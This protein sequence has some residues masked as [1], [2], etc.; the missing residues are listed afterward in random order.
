MLVNLLILALP[1]SGI[2][3]LRI[4][5][6]ALVRQTESE[7]IAQG[8]FI[9]AAYRAA[10]VRILARMKRDVPAREQYGRTIAPQW[11]PSTKSESPWRPRPAVLDLAVDRVRPRPPEPSTTAASVDPVAAEVGR[12]LM[13]LIR[14]AQVTTLASIRVVDYQGMLVASTAERLDA[15]LAKREEIARALAGEPVSLL[16]QRISNEPPPP[17]ASIS[18]GTGVRVFVAMPIV[19]GDRVLGAV[20]LSRTPAEIG[21]ALY[22]KRFLL[23]YAAVTLLGVV[24]GVSM[25]TS[26]AIGRPIR[27]LIQQTQLAARGE[28]GAV[29]PLRQP[30]T[31]EIAQLSEAVAHMA[32]TLEQ[33]ADYIGDFAAHVSHEFKTPLTAI[34]GAVELLRDHADSMSPAEREKFLQNLSDDAVRMENLVR[35]LLDLARADVFQVAGECADAARVLEAVSKRYNTP[36]MRV[37]LSD[38][39]M[40]SVQ[41]AMSK[42]LLE[43]IVANLLENARQ[44]AGDSITVGIDV[45]ERRASED[46][47][48]ILVTDDGPGISEANAARIFDPFF[49]TAR[50]Q[51]G[52][53][54][55]L[56][57]VK[58]LLSAHLGD[59]RRLPSERG[60]TFEIRIPIKHEV[61]G[62]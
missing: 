35:R 48:R 8:A 33:R 15:S 61:S 46:D 6:S 22:H 1:L 42:E 59:I 57:V 12:E 26:F 29:V 40:R 19:Q 14:D 58:S 3:V 56:T 4:Y 13:V 60:T 7:L 47:L 20:M 45:N 10:F 32:R 44:H 39:A 25:L 30:V 37:H 62:C 28:K 43:S 52:T 34:H 16:R 36:G 11:Q 2:T 41:V 51:G 50:K 38:R 9:A 24:L 27:S 31:R 5:E 21:Q 55:G 54:L 18:R 53:G 49:T 17:L 23:L